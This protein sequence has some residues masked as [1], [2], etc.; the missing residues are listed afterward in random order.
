MEIR[1][2]ATPDLKIEAAIQSLPS[3]VKRLLAAANVDLAG[4]KIGVADL[5][6]RLASAER[7]STLDKLALK[8]GLERQGILGD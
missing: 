7:M 3:G 6:R 4:K 2:V 1:A 5:D 8:V